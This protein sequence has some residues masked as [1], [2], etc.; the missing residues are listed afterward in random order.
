MEIQFISNTVELKKNQ[1]EL[2]KKLNVKI[3]ISGKTVE[4]TGSGIDEYEASRVIEAMSI[5]FTAKVALMLKENNLVFKR[6]SM[7]D[8]TPRKDLKTIRARV[9]GKYGQT[10]HTIEEISD[11]YLS[12]KDNDVGIISSPENIE[13]AVT[14]LKNLIRGSKQGNVYHFLE[15]M[16]TSKK[17]IPEDLGLKSPDEPTKFQLK[18]K[19][20]TEK[21]KIKL[22]KEE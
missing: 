20:K 22:Q 2:E 16:N 7:K 21:T 19:K 3:S 11:S 1:K 4:F 5:G 13:E 8:F 10:K 17:T 9:I 18:K 6:L 14:A 12:I 15:S